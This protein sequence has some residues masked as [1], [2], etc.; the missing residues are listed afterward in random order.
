M[1]FRRFSLFNFAFHFTRWN[2]LKLNCILPPF[3]LYYPN[4]S[5]V[6]RVFTIW[7]YQDVK[8]NWSIYSYFRWTRLFSA[9][10]T[11]QLVLIINPVDIFNNIILSTISTW[12]NILKR[13][14]GWSS[15]SPIYYHYPVEICTLTI[16]LNVR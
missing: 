4:V 2:Y 9:Y 5:N 1:P 11:C 10:K 15:F 3:S 7:T 6:L 8:F 12:L 16:T 14:V 13:F